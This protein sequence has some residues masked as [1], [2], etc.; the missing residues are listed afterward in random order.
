MFFVDVKGWNW[1]FGRNNGRL[2]EIFNGLVVCGV[3]VVW[4]N[5]VGVC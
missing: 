1:L 3:V 2:L 4:I 5:E